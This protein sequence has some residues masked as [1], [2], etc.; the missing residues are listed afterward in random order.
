LSKRLEGLPKSDK[1]VFPS[2]ADLE[3]KGRSKKEMSAAAT[4]AINMLDINP[5][6]NNILIILV[7]NNRHLN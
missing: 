1:N 6:D 2:E 5:I 7:I 3:F 4:S